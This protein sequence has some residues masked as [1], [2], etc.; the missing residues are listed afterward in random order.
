MSS[1]V[2]TPATTDSSTL[3]FGPWYR[4]SP[5]FEKT[6]AAGCSAYDIY[7]HMYLPGYYADPV[8]EYWALLNDVTVWDV[9]VERIVEITGPDASA[10]TNSLT[11][12]DLTKCAVG[13][14]KYMLVTADDG[15]IVND[16]VLLRIEANRW[17]LALA[18][19]TRACRPAV[20]PS[21]RDGRHR[22]RAR[23]LPDPGPGAEVEGHDADRLRPGHRRHQ[24]LL[25]AHDRGGRH[26]R[27]H[28]PDRL[29]GRGRLRD[30]PARPVAWRRPVGPGH[31]GRQ[32][33]QDPADRA[34]RGAPHRGRH[35][36][37]RL[38]HDD[39]EQPV[40]GD[41]LGAPGRA[42]GGRLHRQGG[43]RGDPGQGRRPQA[44][45]HRGRRARRCRS[46]CR[47]SA[48]R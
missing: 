7:N 3:Y 38:G 44:R 2:T 1:P 46:S 22:P 12:R 47:A 17:W 29:D 23:G 8:E 11:S 26:P 39:R 27:R 19:W 13:Q 36:Q 5:F 6:L 20:S 42:P 30:L 32:A 14:G 4:R 24:V 10:F 9:S 21:L 37:L 15:G 40:R 41:G 43:A 18:D 33:A 25:D 28:Q 31:G 16:P 35:L 45:G 34:V 48:T